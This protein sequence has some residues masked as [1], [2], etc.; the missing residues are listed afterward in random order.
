MR[1]S[2][3]ATHKG[4]IGLVVDETAPRATHK[5]IIGL[6]VDETAPRATHKGIIGLVVDETAPRA[7][8]KGII[9]LVVDETKPL[10]APAGIPSARCSLAARRERGPGA[11]R[12]LVVM[13]TEID[14]AAARA[15][16]LT[17]AADPVRWRLLATL[18]EG[19]RCVCDLQPV[20]AVA[21]N[22]LSCHLKVL[23]DAKLL[24][25]TKRGRW[26]GY[27]LADDAGLRFGRRPAGGVPYDNPGNL[28][29]LRG[30]ATVRAQAS[31]A[32]VPLPCAR[33]ITERRGLACDDDQQ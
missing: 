14:P 21:P 15:Q 5:G 32:R 7:T 9:G 4:I 31:A 19:P 1:P 6:V 20:A 3:R 16:L 27:R 28:E 23:R 22:V 30:T 8:H 24:E 2:N 29:A 12:P 33:V 17:A 26:A 13:R 18:G 25:G 10:R 11:R